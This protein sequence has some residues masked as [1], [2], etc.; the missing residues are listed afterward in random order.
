M[1]IHHLVSTPLFMGKIF[2]M[3][4]QIDQENSDYYIRLGNTALSYPGGCPSGEGEAP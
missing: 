3:R 2:R 4:L 1:V